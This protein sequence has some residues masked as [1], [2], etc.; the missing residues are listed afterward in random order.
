M[1]DFLSNVWSGV[2]TM[3]ANVAKTGTSAF[4]FL[5]RKKSFGLLDKSMVP[6]VDA[7][8]KYLE[9]KA[10]D[11]KTPDLDKSILNSIKGGDYSA[12]GRSMAMQFAANAPNQAA[13]IAMSFF[14]GPAA[15]LG[16][17]GG[18]TAGAKYEE[19]IKKG[20]DP[21]QAMGNAVIT[22]GIEAGFEN[23]GTFGILK[24][25][26]ASIAKTYGKKISRQ[27]M[28]D[29]AKTLAYSVAAE[30]NEE[31]LTSVAQD[32]TDYIT[33]VNPKA[34]EGMGQRAFDAGVVGGFSGGALVAPMGFAQG[35]AIQHAAKQT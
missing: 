25:W 23:L 29:F 32:F 1:S 35:K 14:G 13:I 15:G 19:N 8:A 20:V 3:G 28:K 7:P 21:S 12:A 31:A 2:N 10:Q 26:E 24:S 30:G 18:T 17:A 22:G 27:V 5:L 6:G 34:L 9:Q 33:G 16:F 11:F 4:D